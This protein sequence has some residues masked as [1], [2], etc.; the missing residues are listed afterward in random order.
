M[1]NTHIYT[2]SWIFFF[3]G[4]PFRSNTPSFP[5]G[6]VPT[7]S[8][9]ELKE[10]LHLSL[11]RFLHGAHGLWLGHLSVSRFRRFSAR[12]FLAVLAG[13]GSWILYIYT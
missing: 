7:L 2:Y 8:F 4:Y 13:A 6:F 9:D 3:L 12:V 10:A 1:I 11:Q 5:F